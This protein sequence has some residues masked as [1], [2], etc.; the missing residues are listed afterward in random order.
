MDIWGFGVTMYYFFTEKKSLFI[1]NQANDTLDG[2]NEELRLANWNGMSEE[3]LNKILPNCD[4]AVFK[5]HAKN[6]FKKCLHADIEERYQT[7]E[8][9]I[10]DPLFAGNKDTGEIICASVREAMRDEAIKIR[11]SLSHEMGEIKEA[12]YENARLMVKM[13]NIQK[14]N[15]LTAPPSK[16]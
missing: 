3:E 2:R 14:K 8:E 6:F 5:T 9:I 4:N 11:E 1:C 16:G 7:M 10:K 12:V 13:E 15:L